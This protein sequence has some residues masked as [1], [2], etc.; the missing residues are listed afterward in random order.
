MTDTFDEILSLVAQTKRDIYKEIG[1]EKEAGQEQLKA[2]RYNLDAALAAS[3]GGKYR[4]A[5]RLFVSLQNLLQENELLQSEWA[6]IYVAQAICYAKLGHKR[7]MELTWQK[8][9]QLEPSNETLKSIAKRLG[10][11]A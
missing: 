6:E 10:L 1:F 3:R 11:L 4:E 2:A 8:A 7:E 5:L 9:Y